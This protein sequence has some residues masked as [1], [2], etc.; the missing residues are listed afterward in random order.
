MVTCNFYLS[1]MQVATLESTSSINHTVISDHHLYIYIA[2]YRIQNTSTW[3]KQKNKSHHRLIFPSSF[4]LQLIQL[5]SSAKSLSEL[6]VLSTYLQRL[7]VNGC[8]CTVLNNSKSKQT[9]NNCRWTIV[10]WG[11]IVA[12][13]QTNCRQ[14]SIGRQQQ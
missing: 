13:L 5:I 14:I 11:Q 7:T 8:R 3:M 2:E 1:S 10:N 4:S 12:K 6:C 9:N